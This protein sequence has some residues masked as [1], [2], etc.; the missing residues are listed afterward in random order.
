MKERILGDLIFNSFKFGIFEGEE[1]REITLILYKKIILLILPFW[2]QFIFLY[3]KLGKMLKK[4]GKDGVIVN[5]Y[6]HF[7]SLSS[8]YLMFRTFKQKEWFFIPLYQVNFLLRVK[9]RYS[10]LSIYIKFSN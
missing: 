9:F 4:K 6:N 3:L 8:L 5:L 10:I 7:L 2:H 1:R